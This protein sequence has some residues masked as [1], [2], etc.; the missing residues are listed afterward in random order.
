MFNSSLTKL[1][2]KDNVILMNFNIHGM[3]KD[4]Q[5]PRNGSLWIATFYCNATLISSRDYCNS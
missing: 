5:T 1:N 4:V 3:N 2:N